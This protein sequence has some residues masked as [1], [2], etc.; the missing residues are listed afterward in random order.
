MKLFLASEAKHP[1]SIQKLE[2]FTGGLKGKKIGYIPTASNGESDGTLPW[3][4]WQS[5]DSWKIVN[6]LGAN[7]EPIILEDH[8]NMKFPDKLMD[9]D[10]IWMAGGACG[11]LMYWIRRTKLDLHLR[12]LL[13]DNTRLYVGS[14]AGSMVTGPNLDICEWCIGDSEIGASTIP[15]LG[16]VDFDFYPHFED[17]LLEEIQQKYKGK[18][19]YLVKN[20]EVI[21]VEDKKITVLGEERKIEK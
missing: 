5:G 10:I 3:G 8:L 16:L 14:S 21:L 6:S 12:D 17:S 20:G 15:S 1:E 18:Y 9:K 7:V 2:N 4:K 13:N 19:M 11:Y